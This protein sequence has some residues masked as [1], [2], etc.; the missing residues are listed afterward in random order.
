MFV[1]YG[2][3]HYVGLVVRPLVILSLARVGGAAS[4]FGGRLSPELYADAEASLLL[5]QS[6]VLCHVFLFFLSGSVFRERCLVSWRVWTEKKKIAFLSGV[7]ER[8]WGWAAFALPRL[9]LTALHLSAY[10]LRGA[11]QIECCNISYHG[12]NILLVFLGGFSGRPEHLTLLSSRGLDRK[13]WSDY[14]RTLKLDLKKW[15]S[16]LFFQISGEKIRMGLF[17]FS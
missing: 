15:F 11:T 9:F 5:F 1:I 16:S 3:F 2:V 4:P 12:N 17:F 10:I 7:M 8:G 6:C 14:G 13:G